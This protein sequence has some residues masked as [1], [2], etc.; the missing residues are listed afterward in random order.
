MSA[1]SHCCGPRP[2]LTAIGASLRASPDHATNTHRVAISNRRLISADDKG[3]ASMTHH[4]HVHMIVEVGPAGD[5]AW[6][7]FGRPQE[8]LRYLARYTRSPT[9][10]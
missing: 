5:P 6:R 4:P 2:L 10:P 8:V 1:C 3:V 7:P 9:S